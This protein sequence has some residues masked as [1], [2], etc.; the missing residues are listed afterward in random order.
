[1]TAFGVHPRM[2]GSKF[3]PR[4]TPA[5]R[6]QN[7]PSPPMPPKWDDRVP[8]IEAALAGNYSDVEPTIKEI[9]AETAR[10]YGLRPAEIVSHRRSRRLIG[11]RQEAMWRCC[12]ETSRSL[13]VIARHFGGR[14]HT[15]IIHGRRQ[16]QKRIDAGQA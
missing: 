1:M 10:K 13:P 15:T 5:V 14:D 4:P 8:D 6:W 2:G 7:I 9:I 3:F 12:M 11:P 16:H